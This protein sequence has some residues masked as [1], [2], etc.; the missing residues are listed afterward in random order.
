MTLLSTLPFGISFFRSTNL[1]KPANNDLTIGIVSRSPPLLPITEYH[2]EWEVIYNYLFAQG[3]IVMGLAVP[4]ASTNR[5]LNSPARA[6]GNPTLGL[7]VRPFFCTAK[8][9]A[10]FFFF[11]VAGAMPKP[12]LGFGRSYSFCPIW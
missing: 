12:H 7:A 5:S 3:S 2:S 6:L 8:M 4:Y 10:F 1:R 9:P 11:F